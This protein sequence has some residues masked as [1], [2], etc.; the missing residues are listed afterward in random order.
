MNSIDCTKQ[1]VRAIIACSRV[2]ED[3]YHAEDTLDWLLRLDPD[4]DDA[5]QIAALGHDI[6]RA[7]EERKVNREDFRD[8]D[9][10][11]AAHAKNSAIILKEIMD[12]CNVPPYVANE[13]YRLVCCHET[14]GDPRS[15]LLKDADSISYFYTNLPLY[16][17]RNGRERAL[18]RS[19]WGYL[20]LS[21]KGR[22]IVQ[23]IHYPN[24][25]LN[26]VLKVTTRMASL[27]GVERS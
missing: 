18:E 5:L 17:N 25:E 20:R 22:R 14:G 9:S 21:P 6:D 24:E 7:V 2:P 4:A 3:P 23:K 12:E 19:I 26:H 10:F 1:K 13:V 16:Y 27:D 8:Y 11:K 15:D